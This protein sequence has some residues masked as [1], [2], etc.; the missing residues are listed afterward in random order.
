ME[1]RRNPSF[2]EIAE[3]T[4][5]ALGATARSVLILALVALILISRTCTIGRR[6]IDQ[7]DLGPWNGHV[8]T[9]VEPVTS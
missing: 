5:A 4:S 6:L 3:A 9:G 2:L 8:L 1:L 7:A